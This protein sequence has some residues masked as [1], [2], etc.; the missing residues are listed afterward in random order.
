MDALVF[1]ERNSRFQMAVDLP[2]CKQDR[3]HFA[4]G[5][6]KGKR[7]DLYQKNRLGCERQRAC[8]IPAWIIQKFPGF[9]TW[10]ACQ[11]IETISEYLSRSDKV[12]EE[13]AYLEELLENE[14]SGPGTN[15]LLPRLFEFLGRS[16]E[17]QLAALN[18][19]MNYFFY[20]EVPHWQASEE[21]LEK[22][23]KITQR[24]EVRKDALIAIRNL[25]GGIKISETI[26]DLV[27]SYLLPIK[28]DEEETTEIACILNFL[29]YDPFENFDYISVI[30]WLSTTFQSSP[31]AAGP[32]CTLALNLLE[33]HKTHTNFNR[34][35]YLSYLIQS[36]FPIH[37]LNSLK[38]IA[39][40]KLH[41]GL[42]LILLFVRNK[43]KVI[44]NLFKAPE[45]LSALYK[46]VSHS[47]YKIK[48]NAFRILK[49]IGQKSVDFLLDT[50]K[51]QE[52]LKD[53]EGSKGEKCK[54]IG[55]FLSELASMYPVI[56]QKFVKL[57]VFN[58][59]ANKLNEGIDAED[60]ENLLEFCIEAISYN[61]ENA[62]EFLNSEVYDLIRG[63]TYKNNP[64]IEELMNEIDLVA[65]W[66]NNDT[67]NELR[68]VA[69]FEFS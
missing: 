17:I 13:L 19:V 31:S 20:S 21:H 55:I 32:C 50:Y 59:M 52:I 26:I 68:P 66:G 48:L 67:E 27:F 28:G 49:K 57:G 38:F 30:H 18:C 44:S 10:P 33:I 60:V 22:I 46:I 39:E 4:V 58:E 15:V 62:N 42:K 23:L 45:A 6:R 43:R 11:R 69:C 25:L 40:T 37:L 29:C 16:G 2:L 5:L 53:F 54:N 64:V 35:A 65:D 24:R 34:S 1:K 41:Q 56:T 51:V 9:G 61:E 7:S 36:N 3:E 63:L 14:Y 8:E 12:L 47:N